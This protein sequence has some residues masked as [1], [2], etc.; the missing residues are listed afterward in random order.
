MG[1]SV[2][3]PP[4][5]PDPYATGRAQTTT[6]VDTAIANTWLQNANERGPLGSVTYNQTGTRTLSSPFFD[7]N[8]NPVTERVWIADPNGPETRGQSGGYY[9]E[10]G[11]YTPPTG[12]ERGRYVDRQRMVEREIPTFEKVTTLSPE[13]QRLYDQQTRAGG[14]LNDLAIGQIGRLQNSMS[15]PISFDG[16][17][18]TQLPPGS[19]NLGRVGGLQLGGV[20]GIGELQGAAAGPQFQGLSDMGALGR[21][22]GPQS[23]GEVGAMG[24]LRR[25]IDPSTYQEAVMS[26]LRPEIDRQRAALEQQLAN[27][28]LTPGSQAWKEATDAFGRQ[29]ND[30]RMQALLQGQQFALTE[31]QFANQATQ[32]AFQG[33]LAQAGFNNQSRQNMFGMGAAATQANNQ[34][35]QAEFDARS[36]QADV[37][38]Q[39]AANLFAANM[40]RAGFNNQTQQQRFD[41]GLAQTGF[42]NQAAANQ[43]QAGLA[44]NAANNQSSMAEYQAG[45]ERAAFANQLRQQQIQERLASRNQ[46]I[47]EISALLGGGQVS[48]PQFPQFR[49]GNIANTPV[50]EY[51]YRG[52]EQESKNW[53]AQAQMQAQAM[54]GMFSL[55]G[56]LISGLFGLSDRRTKR[57]VRQ[58]GTRHDG[59]AVYA[60]RYHWDAPNV[61]RIGV[62]ADEVAKI[63]PDAVTVRAG[64]AHVDYERLAA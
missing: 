31:G 54:G 48:L 50:G 26:R 10:Y 7:K 43:F 12:G 60:W 51:V 52:Y 28:G 21:V 24:D 62:M 17:T 8:G 2:P 41:A 11:G 46:P 15:Q 34:A 36:R 64:I 22:A 19:L 5:P 29:V 25:S 18:E 55:G 30:A 37:A 44:A 40:A 1:K 6:N 38:N 39:N 58:I 14:M 33:Q 20:G 59:L 42:N 56:S 4:P 35:T 61:T 49:A 57:D 47:N 63:Y 9:D 13:Q 23:L 32:D 45:S 16:L 3:S 27:Q 53:Q